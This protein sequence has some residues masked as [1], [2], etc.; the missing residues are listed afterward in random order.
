MKSTSIKNVLIALAGA[1]VLSACHKDKNDPTPDKPTAERAGIYVLNQGNF[2]GN[3]GSLSYYDYASK[4]LTA[5]IFANANGKGLGDTP[6][7][8]KIYGSK[9]YIAV[10]VS[11]TVEVVNA[12][13]GKEIKQIAFKDGSTDRQPRSIAF[14]KGNALITS[15]DGTVAVLDTASLTVSKFI[16]VGRNPEQLVVSNGKLYV[17]NSGGLSF[18][19]PDNTV[20]VIDLNTLRETKKITVIADPVSIAA[21][22]YGH[23]YVLSSGDYA[24]I[25]PG[26]SIID[27]TTDA[28]VSKSTLSGAYGTSIVVSGDLAYFISSD[29]QITVY[30][31]KTLSLAK[32]NFITDGTAIKTPYNLNYDE[33]T[34]ELFVTDAKDFASPG[35]LFA[36][37]KTGKKEYT[38]QVGI[39]PGAILFLNK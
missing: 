37:D 5:D 12:K 20:S 13:T 34:G 39:N 16:T 26:M 29:N 1:A 2:G 21:D 6:N 18:G 7:D 33:T 3:N 36:F 32:A 31:T 25:A 38:L 27:N 4:N 14:Y 24:N 17:A 19:N 9:M 30:N 22:A 10:N 8:A 35:T 28:V 15:Y 11:S 23:V